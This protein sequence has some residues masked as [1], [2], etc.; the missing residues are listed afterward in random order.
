MDTFAERI[1]SFCRDLDFDES[2]PDGI[3]VM[4]PFRNNSGVLEAVSQF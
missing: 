3:S 1:I 2:L 4:N